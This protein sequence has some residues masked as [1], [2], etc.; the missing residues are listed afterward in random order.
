MKKMDFEQDAQKRLSMHLIDNI[1]H[2]QDESG[3]WYLFT[4]EEK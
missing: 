1:P 2:I 3:S 4:K